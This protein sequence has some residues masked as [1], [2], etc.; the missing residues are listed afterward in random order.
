MQLHQLISI[1]LLTHH[2]SSYLYIPVAYKRIV[3]TAKSS[4]HDN[5]IDVAFDTLD[6]S[7]TGHL[8]RCDI[9][10]FLLTAAAHTKLEDQVN[11]SVIEAAVDALI[12]DLQGSD[13][14]DEKVFITK[15]QFHQLFDRHPDLLTAFEDDIEL[16]KRRSAVLSMIS[17][18]R[19]QEWDI[20]DIQDETLQLVLV[21]T[22]FASG[23]ANLPLYTWHGKLARTISEFIL[24][25]WTTGFICYTTDMERDSSFFYRCFKDGDKNGRC[26]TVEVEEAKV[27]QWIHQVGNVWLSQCGKR[28]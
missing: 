3:S 16:S 21:Y 9:Q 12:W 23:N 7:N 22:S 1:T 5:A 18:E 8:N 20:E 19:Q 27:L 28:I 13:D 17:S 14:N 4:G 26:G 2:N 24:D 15:Q 10:Q 25:N 6:I 11:E